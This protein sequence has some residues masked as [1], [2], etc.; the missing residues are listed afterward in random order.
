MGISR[1]QVNEKR[2]KWNGYFLGGY[3]LDLLI[4]KGKL[5][6]V[7]SCSFHLQI[8]CQVGPLRYFGFVV[9]HTVARFCHFP[10]M[11]PR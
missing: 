10:I 1:V 7:S 9:S 3:V 2:T 5:V 4:K 6:E 8:Q 11:I